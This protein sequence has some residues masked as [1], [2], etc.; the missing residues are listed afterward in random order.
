MLAVMGQPDTEYCTTSNNGNKSRTQTH[1]EMPQIIPRY[2]LEHICDRAHDSH[3]KDALMTSVNQ[4][5]NNIDTGTELANHL[6]EK[7]KMALLPQLRRMYSHAQSHEQ[8]LG[9]RDQ[10]RSQKSKQRN[11]HKFSTCM[12]R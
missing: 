9:M 4:E 10:S 6:S 1:G 3:Q 2:S 5:T 12:T 7:S 8:L 11:L